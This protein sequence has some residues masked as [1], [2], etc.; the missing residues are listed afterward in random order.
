ML[1]QISNLVGVKKLSRAEKL[2]VQG[3]KKQCRIWNTGPCTDYGVH[4]AEEEC[5]M[6]P[7]PN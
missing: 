6:Y 5:R 2:T 3:G 1:Q 7:G 4:C